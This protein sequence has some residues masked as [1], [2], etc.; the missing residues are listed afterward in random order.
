MILDPTE[1]TAAPSSGAFLATVRAEALALA[2]RTDADLL[3][4]AARVATLGYGG[5]HADVWHLG[6]DLGIADDDFG[7]LVRE[8]LTTLYPVATVTS[9][10]RHRPPRRSH[11]LASAHDRRETQAARR[12]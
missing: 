6:R 7:V 2:P 4:L 3:A 10:R 9:P 8:A 1:H 11:R 12:A 5:A